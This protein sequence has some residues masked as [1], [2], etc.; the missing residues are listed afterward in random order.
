M[1][2]NKT[3]K[4]LIEDYEFVGYIELFEECNE[5][6]YYEVEKYY[7]GG[8]LVIRKD[9]VCEVLM[10]CLC[11][12]DEEIMK[13]CYAYLKGNIDDDILIKL[14]NIT[15]IFPNGLKEIEE[16]QNME[17]EKRGYKYLYNNEYLMKL[18]IN[19]LKNLLN[20]I[21]YLFEMNHGY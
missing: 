14:I 8:E 16:F 11:Y 2:S 21:I 10:F 4:T 7:S 20:F 15:N 12:K 18:E 19:N 6:G 9:N 1:S 5:I 3:L 17:Y 13:D